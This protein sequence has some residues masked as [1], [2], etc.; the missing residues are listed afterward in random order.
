MESRQTNSNV[1][2]DK[3][4]VEFPFHHTLSQLESDTDLFQLR[5]QELGRLSVEVHQADTCGLGAHL[6]KIFLRIQDRC[7]KI[8]LGRRICTR[9]GVRS[10]CVKKEKSE[11]VHTT[12]KHPCTLMSEA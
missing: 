6:Y 9:H 12:D 2:A 1:M 3:M 5:G 11:L 7:V 8:P 4:G 10:C